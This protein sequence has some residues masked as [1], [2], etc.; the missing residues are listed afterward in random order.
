MYIIVGLGNPEDKYAGTR[1]NIGF[2]VI[3]YF[4]EDKN[5]EM[6]KRKH[7]AIIGEGFIEREKVMLV[8][9]QTFMNLSGESVVEIVNYYD[10]PLENLLVI[11]DDID[12]ERGI[13]RLRRKGSAGTHN[14]MR[15]ILSQMQNDKFPRLRV[16]IGRP[17]RGDL[18]DFVIGKLSSEERKHMGQAVKK[19]AQAVEVFITSG[20]TEAMNQFNG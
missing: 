17:E 19:A 1:H 11:Y 14:G 7:K 8:K 5:I 15:S 10:I 9:P 12:L 3:N 20:I 16:G 6:R 13:L 2:D 4:A 18:I